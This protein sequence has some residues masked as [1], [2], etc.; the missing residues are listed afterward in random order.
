MLH[1]EVLDSALDN[2]VVGIC[3]GRTS[4]RRLLNEVHDL[5][6]KDG[7]EQIIALST[8]NHPDAELAYIY[9]QERYNSDRARAKVIA[10]YD[11]TLSRES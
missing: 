11:L 9:D 3:G 2:G 5:A 4:V 10:A 8:C 6:E 7:H 1:G